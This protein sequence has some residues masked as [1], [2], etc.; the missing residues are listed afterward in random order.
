M[1]AIFVNY[2]VIDIA[3]LMD[4]SINWAIPSICFDKTS[5]SGSYLFHSISS[6]QAQ[7]SQVA[8]W[9]KTVSEINYENEVEDILGGVAVFHGIK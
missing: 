4:R 5:F 3:E 6:N 1:S 9:L 7:Y 8:Y 2:S